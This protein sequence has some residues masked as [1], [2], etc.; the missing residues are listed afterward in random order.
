M[1]E[2]RVLYLHNNVLTE[3]EAFRARDVLEAIDRA[4]GRSP[5]ISAEIWSGN[6]RVAVV[7][8]F[9]RNESIVPNPTRRSD[10]VD[11]SG[12]EIEKLMRARLD[13]A[14]KERPVPKI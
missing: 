9:P 1:E 14:R 11:E 5:D 2:F 10:A 7:G 12:S 4:S 13:L 6:R 3:S 8:P